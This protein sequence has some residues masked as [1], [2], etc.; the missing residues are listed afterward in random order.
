MTVRI[1]L[2]S[3]AVYSSERRSDQQSERIC[4]FANSPV[5]TPQGQLA[6]TLVMLP[7]FSESTQIVGKHVMV[8]LRQPIVAHN[9][10]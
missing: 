9:A 1:S 10:P 2:L 4:G 3:H 5:A 7:E 6:I 8:A